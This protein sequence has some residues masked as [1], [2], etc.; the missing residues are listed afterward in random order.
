MIIELL[1]LAIGLGLVVSLL[2]SESFGLAPGGL[3]VPG[4]IALAMNEPLHV[5]FTVGAGFLTYLFVHALS[6][7]LIVF[8]RR[9][10][11]LMILTGY[12]VGMALPMIFESTT[13]GV[14]GADY[15]VIGY[16]IP[17][18]IGI[19]LDRQRVLET[20]STLLIVSVIVR[21]LLIVTVGEK[22]LT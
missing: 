16:I 9:R 5:A 8:G 1:P 15:R 13:G 14:L 21:L 20:V 7:V 4:Y 11:V 12:I 10:T 2:F 19:W 18:L 6:S 17:G 22:L 3:V